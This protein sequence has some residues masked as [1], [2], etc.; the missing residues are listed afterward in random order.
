MTSCLSNCPPTVYCIHIHIYIYIHQTNFT[1]KQNHIEIQQNPTN[2][3]ISNHSSQ[4]SKDFKGR[5]ITILQKA[6]GLL[7]WQLLALATSILGVVACLTFAES[8][9]W[10]ESLDCRLHLLL[11]HQLHLPWSCRLSSSK[12]SCTWAFYAIRIDVIEAKENQ[13]IFTWSILIKWEGWKPGSC[14][15]DWICWTVWQARS[16]ANISVQKSCLD[17]RG[18]R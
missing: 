9:L 4:H 7:C 16:I 14:L 11:K 6:G 17:T 12:T 8:R 1:M 2:S 3:K 10:R 15:V 13:D 5:W 18:N